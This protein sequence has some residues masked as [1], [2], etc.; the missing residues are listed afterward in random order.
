VEGRL[1]RSCARTA[2]RRRRDRA[3]EEDVGAGGERRLGLGVPTPEGV[4][5]NNDLLLDSQSLRTTPYIIE[6]WA[7]PLIR[8]TNGLLPAVRYAGHNTLHI[9]ASIYFMFHKEKEIRQ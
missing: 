8:P 3:E 9:D 4:G 1:A 2:A 7:N 5:N 6:N